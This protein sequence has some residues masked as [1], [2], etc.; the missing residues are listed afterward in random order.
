MWKEIKSHWMV[1]NH[2]KFSSKNKNFPQLNVAPL[3]EEGL[4]SQPHVRLD[5]L[6]ECNSSTLDVESKKTDANLF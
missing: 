1:H 4:I 2:T 3:I 5:G 6:M